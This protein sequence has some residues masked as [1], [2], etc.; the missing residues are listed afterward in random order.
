MRKFM[1]LLLLVG[2]RVGPNYHPPCVEEPE[3]WKN[4]YTITQKPNL[5]AWWEV[6]DDPVLNE[7]ECQAVNNSPNLYVA[8]RRVD[9]AWA[10]VGVDRANL[11]PQVTLNPSYYNT[12]TLFQLFLPQ[13]AQNILPPSF[14]QL[15]VFRV[16]QQQYV[17][18]LNLS[19]ELDLWGKYR[20]QVDASVRHAEALEASYCASLLT[21]TTD[22]AVA[23]YNLRVL[24]AQIDLLRSKVGI[25]EKD[26]NIVHS[27]YEKG[28]VN[29]V[30]VTNAKLQL[31]NTKA[32]LA[33]AERQR[34]LE[35]NILAVFVGENASSFHLDPM[36]TLGAPPP[37]SPGLPSEVLKHR[38]DLAQAEREMASENALIGAAFANYFPTVE[39]TGQLGF[40]SPLFKEFLSWNSRLWSMGANGSQ[41]VFD[42]NRVGYNVDAS[43]ERFFQA[44]GNYQ[45]TVLTAFREVEDAL[46][47][48]EYYSREAEALKVSVDAATQT[49]ELSN[50]RYLKGISNF[51][52][53]IDAERSQLD[54]ETSY[55]N[56]LSLQYQST[57]Q[58]IK[59]T[60][61]C[62]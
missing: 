21:L 46:H 25:R 12:G 16:H 50:K 62:F 44:S 48:I 54:A 56:V 14:A 24:D 20:S 18:P 34:G 49:Y 29:Y 55:L 40:L 23:Y 57:I 1:L 60:G 11:Y 32:D 19:Y 38:P 8:M 41:V 17:L 9:E 2:C 27:R 42:A 35:E 22:L 53:V 10:L 51:L 31:Y 7:L 59:A 61:G 3:D 33:E 47:N 26:F 45:Q 39:L 28:L 52:N 13:A 43:W 15:E 36:P 37:V 5:N 58:L 6:F 30:D 4:P